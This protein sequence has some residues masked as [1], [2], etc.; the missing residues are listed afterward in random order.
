VLLHGPEQLRQF[1]IEQAR[2]WGQVISE[3]GIKGDV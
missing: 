3:N 1:A 2:L